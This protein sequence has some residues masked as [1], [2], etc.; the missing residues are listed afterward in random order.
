MDIWWKAGRTAR[1]VSGRASRCECKRS[2]HIVYKLDLG[3]S[4]RTVLYYTHN[5][6]ALSNPGSYGHA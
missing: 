1:W 2:V 6:I 5:P 4:E 3:H